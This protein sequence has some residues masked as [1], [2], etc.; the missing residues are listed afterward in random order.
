YQRPLLRRRLVT[1]RDEAAQAVQLPPD[2]RIET[3]PHLSED[4]RAMPLHT[5]SSGTGATVSS[6]TYAPGLAS[7]SV[8]KRRMPE[9]GVPADTAYAIVSDELLL[10]GNS[11][12]NL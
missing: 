6:A 11:R 10:D 4:T 7:R 12:Q 5:V 2:L 3:G 1:P 9:T 8:P